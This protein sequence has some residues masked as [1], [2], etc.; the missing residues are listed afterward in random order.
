MS[1]AGLCKLALSILQFDVAAEGRQTTRNCNNQVAGD[2]GESM[3]RQ[4]FSLGK[5]ILAKSGNI[6]EIFVGF[7]LFFFFSWCV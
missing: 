5:Q 1:L 4:N 6:Q 3:F 7:F 2:G